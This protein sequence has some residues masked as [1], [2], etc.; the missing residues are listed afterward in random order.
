VV[1]VVEVEESGRL[2]SSLFAGFGNEKSVLIMFFSVFVDDDDD[3]DS[4]I[5]E[6]VSEIQKNYFNIVIIDFTI[7]SYSSGIWFSG[8]FPSKIKTGICVCISH[9]L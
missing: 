7:F 8:L 9:C 3:D 2:T 4:I 5:G 6:V 1:V